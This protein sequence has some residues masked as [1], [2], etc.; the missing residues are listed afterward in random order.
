MQKI[1]CSSFILVKAQ[2]LV[3]TNLLI[4]SMNGSPV[5][6]AEASIRFRAIS[7]GPSKV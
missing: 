2:L 4:E 5:P 7:D 1:A 3:N 6:N